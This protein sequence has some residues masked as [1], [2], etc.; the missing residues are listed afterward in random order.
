M[1]DAPP[2]HFDRALL[3]EREMR[4]VELRL[5]HAQARLVEADAGAAELR[6]ALQERERELAR[7]LD[8]PARLRA[9]LDRERSGRRWAEQLAQAERAE[10]EAL[11][12]ELGRLRA[13][14]LGR[15]QREAEVRA[16][17][18]RVEELQT[19]AVRLQRALAEA[20]HLVQ[21]ARAGA[22]GGET[23][24]A[25]PAAAPPPPPPGPAAAP[26]PRPAAVPPPP[27]R[28][29][30]PMAAPSAAARDAP[31]PAPRVAPPPAGVLPDVPPA[32]PAQLEV[33]RLSEA[34]VRL[35]AGAE[36]PVLPEPEPA[37][38]PAPEAG[39]RGPVADWLPRALSRILAE[40]PSAAGRIILGL[41]PAQHLT[42]PG[43]LAYDLLLGVDGVAEVTVADGA[44][45]V[46]RRLPAV[47]GAP[48]SG[49]D[50]RSLDFRVEGD[51]AGVARWLAG[52]SRTLRR[53]VR[54]HGDEGRAAALREL[55]E[56]PRPLE[57][58]IAAGVRMTPLQTFT[59]VAG[60]IA[61]VDRGGRE[62]TLVHR[63]PGG[64][65]HAHLRVRPDEP[66]VALLGSA[67]ES[68]ATVLV[69]AE[70]TLLEVLGSRRTDGFEL[71]GSAADL[72]AVREW[73]E[74]AQRP[75]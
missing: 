2:A 35:R 24:T 32:A 72:G 28:P 8:E 22:R 33:D 7:A 37:L 16:L 55:V 13:G 17:R 69:C 63:A 54:L 56:A 41:L 38:V 27:P 43:A 34:L 49:R 26:P 51:L 44:T 23:L 30:A 25:P 10:R 45:R 68:G 59:L 73:V 71:L 48:V 5:V 15:S 57:E 65:D 52:R 39:L 18:E 42:S 61:G 3:L 62:F 1:H 21:A 11:A 50:P 58:L 64:L 4:V 70:Q 67:R 74:L 6:S 20:E 53:P 47:L 60:M 14:P 46:D 19:E 31:P 36:P 40:N 12:E 66:P 75:G 29:P 9:E